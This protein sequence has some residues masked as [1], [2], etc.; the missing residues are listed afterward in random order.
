MNF[1][2]NADVK[3]NAKG[4][5]TKIWRLNE[6]SKSWNQLSNQYAMSVYYTA[7]PVTWK[8]S[9]QDGSG[10]SYNLTSNAGDLNIDGTV[11]LSETVEAIN[12]YSRGEVT[13]AY[14]DD[15]I[16]NWASS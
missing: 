16:K 13:K 3:V 9:A 12:M 8:F 14:V 15:A 1:K 4:V 11:T 6:A 5:D 2:S 7:N 10:D